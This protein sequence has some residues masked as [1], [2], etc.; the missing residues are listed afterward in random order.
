MKITELNKPIRPEAQKLL[1]KLTSELAELETQISALEDQAQERKAVAAWLNSPWDYG[2]IV[3][4]VPWQGSSLN[5]NKISRR[6]VVLGIGFYP[7]GVLLKND[8]TL[9][10]KSFELFRDCE[11][12]DRYTG[13]DLP[14]APAA[15]TTAMKAKGTL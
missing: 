10:I 15:A 4:E 12:V 5:S 8:G 13:D 1:K 9:G 3:E 11:L 7:C 2:D 6:F 14:P